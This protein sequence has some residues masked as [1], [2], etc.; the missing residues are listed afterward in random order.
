[1]PVSNGPRPTDTGI[2]SITPTDLVGYTGNAINRLDELE[3]RVAELE[4]KLVEAEQLSDLAAQAGW[5]EGVTYMGIEGWTQTPAGT[6]IPPAGVTLSS[7]GIIPPTIPG[8]PG[9]QFSIF[10]EDGNLIFGADQLGALFG[11]QVDIWNG[12][13]EADYAIT[14]FRFSDGSYSSSRGI[15]ITDAAPTSGEGDAKLQVAQDG[16]Y[17]VNGSAS[18]SFGIAHAY[19]GTL[20]L[21]T[22]YPEQ[23]TGDSRNTDTDSTPILTW[24][25]ATIVNLL[26]GD[27]IEL[28]F[29]IGGSTAGGTLSEFKFSAI[30]LSS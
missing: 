3:Q 27:E 19:S 20:R 30:R 23:D 1:M 4:A 25:I 8:N 2:C 21:F 10:D 9:M 12:A 14:S 7:L 22:P 17:Q 5:I 18:W 28:E 26:A 15:T 6:L 11:N 29:D 16:I 13:S 24:K